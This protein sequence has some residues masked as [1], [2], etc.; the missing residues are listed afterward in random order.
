MKYA[1]SNGMSSEHCRLCLT[2]SHGPC[3]ELVVDAF[4]CRPDWEVSTSAEDAAC[5]DGVHQLF[6]EYELIDWG[7]VHGGG[8]RANCYCVRKGLI[9]KAQLAVNLKKWNA[10]HP[11][12]LLARSVPETYYMDVD[13][14]DYFEE[15]LCEIPEAGCVLC[16]SLF[17][18]L[19]GK[20]R[21][22]M[23]GGGGGGGGGRLSGRTASIQILRDLRSLNGCGSAGVLQGGPV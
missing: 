21:R 16:L 11:E 22:K 7:Q 17:V 18:L 2:Q 6:V 23:G 3:S 9:R 19:F 15:A 12:G 10:K 4:Q 20:H 14:P 13:H 5:P 8:L 1:L